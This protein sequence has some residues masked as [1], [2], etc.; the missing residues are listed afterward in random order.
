M[1]GNQYF[2]IFISIFLFW[3]LTLIPEKITIVISYFF[4]MTLGI[5]HGSN[6]LQII[7]RLES[8]IKLKLISITIYLCVIFTSIILLFFFE[9]LAYL[10]FIIFSSYHFG[11]QHFNAKK[12]TQKT[13]KYVLYLF[14][15]IVIFSLIFLNKIS[16]VVKISKELFSIT[17][18]ENFLLLFSIIS[19]SIYFLLLLFNYYINNDYKTIFEEILY[20]CFFYV[21]FKATSLIVGFSIYFIIWH[22]VPS[23]LDQ[24]KFLYAG[25]SRSLLALYLKK[26]F[27]LWFGSILF[28]GSFYLFL[29]SDYLLESFIFGILFIISIPHILVISIMNYVYKKL[30]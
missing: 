23:I 17:L 26:S 18:T 29:G 1:I 20:C 14:H 21:L 30:Y 2:K 24:I 12:F 15:G 25:S 11:E 8:T 9:K 27:L 13:N 10:L 16:E 3:F 5:I 7:R 28:I 22:S 4:V 6:D 19:T